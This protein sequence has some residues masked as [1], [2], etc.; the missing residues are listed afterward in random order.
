M[1][2][3]HFTLIEL[4]IVVAIIAILA[5][6]L[7]PALNAARNTAKAIKCTANVK[8]LIQ[9]YQMY[10]DDNGE[11]MAAGYMYTAD[12]VTYYPWTSFVAQLIC[13]MPEAKRA[14][15][16][17][18][19]Y[20]KVFECPNEP[21]PQGAS[22]SGGFAYG[23]YTLNGMMCGVSLDDATYHYRK[24]SQIT[25]P[26]IALTI[27]DGTFRDKPSLYTI[28]TGGKSI[29]T[30]HGTGVVRLKE[31]SQHGCLAGQ[32]MNGTYLDGHVNKIM[33]TEWAKA[34]GSLSRDLLRQGYPNDYSL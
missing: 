28:G 32:F 33:R 6:M 23:H 25:K 20:Y 12:K 26:G 3:R 16:T 31:S 18:K 34:T 5:G 13:G 21:D 8:Q 29:G 1:K 4:L 14:F 22:S 7:L 24:I 30:R 10:T 15:S 11:W 19:V 27:M 17:Y 2:K 9:G